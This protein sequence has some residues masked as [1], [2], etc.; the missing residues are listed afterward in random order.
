VGGICC[1]G[2]EW[3]VVDHQRLA[4]L[5]YCFSAASPPFTAVA[6]CTSLKLIEE[7]GKAA[8]ARLR[9]NANYVRQK[10]SHVPG[11]VV[12]GEDDDASYVS[13]RVCIHLSDDNLAGNEEAEADVLLSVYEDMLNRGIYIRVPEVMSKEAKQLRPSVLITVYATHTEEDIDSLVFELEECLSNA[14][15]GG[16]IEVSENE[17]E[18]EEDEKLQQPVKATPRRTSAKKKKASAKTA[19]RSSSRPRRSTRKD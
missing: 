6:A 15:L 11:I 9:E 5:G 14:L 13:P 2:N 8:C 18:E 4:G 1:G 17:G 7:E 19:P 16:G 10:L 3:Q 12:A